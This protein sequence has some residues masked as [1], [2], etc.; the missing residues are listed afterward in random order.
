MKDTFLKLSTA[1]PTGTIILNRPE[2]QN[3]LTPA[4]VS[5]LSEA[6]DDLYYTK[7]IRAIVITGAGDTFSSGLDHSQDISSTAT[8]AENARRWGEEA[9]V[10][11]ELLV[12]MLEI[13]KP[14]IAAV[15]GP[16]LSAGAAIAAAA[17]VVVAGQSA[18]F[19]LNDAR[20]GRIAGMASTLVGFRLGAGQ[21]ARL[22]LTSATIDATEAY[23]LGLFHEL[24][25]DEQTWARANQLAEECA[26]GAPE[27]IQLTKRLINE[28]LGETLAT[29]L[30]AAAVLSATAR[31]TAAAAEGI[32]AQREGRPPEWK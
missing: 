16:A 29:Q 3:L 10:F 32:A 24:V 8:E 18:T 17:D 19:G 23:R 22:A 28:T 6:L 13:T 11:C 14:I 30:S 12:R 9:Q 20:H 27:A 21:A 15:N 25:D 26:A 31:T 2:Q 4:M 1:G 7:S 5:E